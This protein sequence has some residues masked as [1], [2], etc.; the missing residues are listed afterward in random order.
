MRSKILVVV[1][2]IFLVLALAGCGG[3]VTPDTNVAKQIKEVICD[4]WEA[5]SDRQWELAFSYCI[6]HGGFYNLAE[7]FQS[8]PY[9]GDIE[10]KFYPYFD[11]ESIEVYGNTALATIELTITVTVCFGQ[12]CTSSSETLY[13]YPMALVRISGAWKLK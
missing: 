1:L 4:Y 9:F 8:L 7:E 10:T 6:L 12:V 3:L 2:V 11:W 13:N 5:L